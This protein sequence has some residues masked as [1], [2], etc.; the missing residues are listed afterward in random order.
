ML[1]MQCM[2]EQLGDGMGYCQ[3]LALHARVM[4]LPR[5]S[6]INTWKC[7]LLDI[8]FGGAKMG[9]AVDPR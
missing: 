4:S 5:L 7:A 3:L 8:P 9:I 1:H 2:G 6:A